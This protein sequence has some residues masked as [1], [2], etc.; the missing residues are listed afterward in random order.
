M[1]E[2]PSSIITFASNQVNGKIYSL[3]SSTVRI[4]ALIS[5]KGSNLQALIDA[6]F[7][8]QLP[9]EIVRVISNRKE[10]YGLTRAAE[11]NIP[12]SYHN[13]V[14]YKRKHPTTHEGVLTAREEYDTE[15]A[16]LVLSDNP[17]LVA[18]L[19][20][21]H[22]VST[23]FLDPLERAGV[24]IIN[25]HPALP[26]RF[27]GAVSLTISTSLFVQCVYCRE[28][29]LDSIILV[30]LTSQNALHRAHT[31]WKEG[32][33]DK[34]GVMIH[35]V[36]AE[37]DMGTPILVREIPFKPDEDCDLEAFEQRVHKIEWGAVVEGTKI[38]VEDILRNKI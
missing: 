2:K 25:L 34:T 29:L 24:Q 35:K 1:I 8:R 28:H 12:T 32:R 15:L 10:A 7:N 11:A 9:A 33:I 3:M 21:M 4:T 22:V 17:D 5:G 6:T 23:K 38:A 20:F 16:E 31:A 14:K 19:G 26:G 37:V 13:L 36:I 27:N 18:C 30:T